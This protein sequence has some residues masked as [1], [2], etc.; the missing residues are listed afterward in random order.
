MIIIKLATA[1]FSLIDQFLLA[2]VLYSV[3]YLDK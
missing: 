3:A 2:V 1:V